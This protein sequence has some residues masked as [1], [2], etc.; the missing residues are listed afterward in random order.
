M[1]NAAFFRWI[2]V[3]IRFKR[4]QF[5]DNRKTFR[6]VKGSVV[7]SERIFPQEKK[8]EEKIASEGN[9]LLS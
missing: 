2:T 9:Y 8:E 4:I 3:I 5:I 1:K 7:W 6:M